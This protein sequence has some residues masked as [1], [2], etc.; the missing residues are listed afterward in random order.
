M[1]FVCQCD[2]EGLYDDIV[3]AS[4]D[5]VLPANGPCLPAI[6]RR[7]G[8]GIRPGYMHCVVVIPLYDLHYC[9]IIID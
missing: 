2:E 3:E 8:Y 7:G 9:I 1:T 6:S 5:A 4:D